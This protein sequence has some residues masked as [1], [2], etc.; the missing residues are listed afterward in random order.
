M[1]LNKKNN[2][3]LF[4]YDHSP[5]TGNGHLRRCEYFSRIFPK[6]YKIDY[7]K[8]NTEIS[9]NLSKKIYKYIVIDSYK[10]SFDIEKKITKYCEKLI[11]IDDNY[12]RKFAS[13]LIINYSSAV[14][15]KNYLGKYSKYS[16]LFLGNRF[17]FIKSIKALN[18]KKKWDQKRKINI[19]I[20]FGK[21]NRSVLI[22]KFINKIK[23][24]S[25]INKVYVFNQKKIIP[26]KVFLKKIIKSDL[27][28]ISSGVTL[29]EGL[30][31]RKMIFATFFSKN[32]KNF[33]QYYMKK[34][35]IRDLNHFDKFINLPLRK[36]NF[37]LKRNT[38]KINKYLKVKINNK[39]FWFL[40][41]NV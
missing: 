6:N 25:I 26:H 29:Q 24:K 16:K 36:I 11:T 33:H 23:D 12:D 10:I 5:K 28:L 38:L 34:H 21:K 39:K 19:F 31:M 2:F 17:N 9:K 8:Y 35:L 13:D 27:L 14:N 18:E 15:R 37:F 4:I 30:N 3:V 1:I 32:Q 22:K 40:V 7:K 20:Y 41:K